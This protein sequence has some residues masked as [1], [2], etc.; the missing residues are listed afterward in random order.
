MLVPV[1]ELNSADEVLANARA[2]KER[3][4]GRPAQPIIKLQAV[5]TPDLLAEKK[6]REAEAAAQEGKKARKEAMRQ[7]AIADAIEKQRIYDGLRLAATLIARGFREGASGIPYTPPEMDKLQYVKMREVIRFVVTASPFD[8]ES[9][10]SPHRTADL[11][12]YRQVLAW[13]LVVFSGRS[14]PFIGHSLGN[15]DHTTILHSYRKIEA[16]RNAAGI[17]VD[18]KNWMATINAVLEAT[19]R[20][21]GRE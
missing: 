13:A 6:R 7:K 12:R 14:L 1:R 3:L 19:A 2:V 20:R 21:G 9:I 11:V 16:L 10:L 17:K 4:R 18:R 8:L 15:R 5:G